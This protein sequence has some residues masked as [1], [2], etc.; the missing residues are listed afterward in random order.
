MIGGLE[1]GY[2]ELPLDVQA[3]P[4]GIRYSSLFYQSV[5]PSKREL[6]IML[7]LAAPRRVRGSAARMA[8]YTS[9]TS[10]ISPFH[11]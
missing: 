5:P 3:K 1:K 11:F 9:E 2:P 7:R 8:G 4:L 6:A 10:L